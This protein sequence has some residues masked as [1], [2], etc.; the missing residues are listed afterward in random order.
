MSRCSEFPIAWC[1]P[2]LLETKIRTTESDIW[3]LGITYWEIFTNGRRPF[4]ELKR[5]KIYSLAK[6]GKL[7]LNF[8]GFPGEKFMKCCLHFNPRKRPTAQN[9]NKFWQEAKEIKNESKE[10]S[11]YQHLS[12]GFF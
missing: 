5:E 1:S 2:E 8:H 11:F 10:E 7:E 12:R 3:A 9:V 6:K 4:S